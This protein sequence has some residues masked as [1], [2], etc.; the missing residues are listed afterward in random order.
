MRSKQRPWYT[1]RRGNTLVINPDVDRD[2]LVAERNELEGDLKRILREIELCEDYKQRI[3]LRRQIPIII[4]E[5]DEVEIDIYDSSTAGKIY[6]LER[7]QKL[8]RLGAHK[9]QSLLHQL[10]FFFYDFD[11]EFR[12]VSSTRNLHR[13]RCNVDDPSLIDI[14][15]FFVKATGAIKNE[16]AKAFIKYRRYRLQIALDCTFKDL[17]A[18]DDDKMHHR[19][20]FAMT[21]RLEH[22]ITIN[23]KNISNNTINRIIDYF[24]QW[25]ENE[26]QRNS[27]FALERINHIDL[28]FLRAPSIKG[29]S[30]IPSPFRNNFILN[31]HNT[32]DY[33]I[34]YCIDAALNPI[35]PK[36]HP[37]RPGKYNINNYETGKLTFPLCIDDITKLERMNMTTV[38]KA[39]GGID[40]GHM[41]NLQLQQ[42][43]FV[44]NVYAYDEEEGLCVLRLAKDIYSTIDANVPKINLLLIKQEYVSLTN[45]PLAN[46]EVTVAA[47]SHYCLIKNFQSMMNSFHNTAGYKYCENCLCGFRQQETLNKHA[48]LC[49]NT[50]GMK[51]QLPVSK[52]NPV[53]GEA[54]KPVCTFRNINRQVKHPF[55]LYFDF[56]SF[57]VAEGKV[58]EGK[59]AEDKKFKHKA[60]G[61]SI[62]CTFNNELY[63]NDCNV[64]EGKVAETITTSNN[65]VVNFVEQLK[66]LVKLYAANNDRAM[67]PLSSEVLHQH[68]R[69][70]KCYICKKAFGI[71]TTH[72]N[73]P[74]YQRHKVRDHCHVT[75]KYRGA[76][77]S[78]CNLQVQTPD[79]IPIFAHN[80]TG[81][82]LHLFI[83]ELCKVNENLIQVDEDTADAAAAGHPA[84]ISIIPKSAEKYSAISVKFLIKEH[85]YMDK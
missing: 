8:T 33:C 63:T 75:G 43:K 68:N 74:D 22:A 35:G 25:V 7:S 17:S 10:P 55:A 49:E 39:R 52:I 15:A 12:R 59:V 70:N 42:A 54:E 64:A 18:N 58:A 82:D 66:S 60:S 1:H 53:T 32:D 31:I 56:E 48:A 6:T 20:V 85:E 47:D 41:A 9:E 57:Q 40:N 71:Y 79:F 62:Y 23:T 27:G 50:K 81:Y 34:L 38:T 29:R 13:R 11:P 61:Y 3:I 73:H 14:R 4:K 67:I 28:E 69:A 21:K 5:L 37:Q 77:H 45:E 36:D 51:I 80:L 30:Y 19:D 46:E 44:I 76:A 72:K 83:N 84:G 16:C 24:E 2:N 26:S 78:C 65:L